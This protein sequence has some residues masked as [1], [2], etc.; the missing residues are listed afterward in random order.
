MVTARVAKR[1]E[2]PVELAEWL[3][4][5]SARR[6]ITQLQIVIEA[7]ESERNGHDNT[8]IQDRTKTE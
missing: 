4:Q 8:R 3:E 5:E 1:F 2:L 6:G 7:L